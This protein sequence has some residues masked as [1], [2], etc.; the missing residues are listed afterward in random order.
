MKLRKRN[1]IKVNNIEFA[2]LINQ[3]SINMLENFPRSA[4]IKHNE[5]RGLKTDITYN[6]MLHFSVLK[7]FKMNIK[8]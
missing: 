5:R 7:T 2:L 1:R 8:N 3:Y 4:T 6:I